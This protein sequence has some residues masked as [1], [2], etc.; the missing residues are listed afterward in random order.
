MKVDRYKRVRS[1]R[2]MGILHANKNGGPVL[3]GHTSWRTVNGFYINTGK[4]GMV[5]I[6]FRRYM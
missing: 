5:C 2:G 3:K 1:F 4:T 6:Q